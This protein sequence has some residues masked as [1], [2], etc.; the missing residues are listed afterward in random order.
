M[1]PVSDLLAGIV[2]K[3]GLR[4]VMISAISVMELEHGL[5]RAETPE[6]A[7][8][9]QAWIDEVYAAIPVQPFTKAMGQLTAKIDAEARRSGKVIPLA[10]LQIGVTAMHF[11]FELG[12]VNVRHFRLIPNLAVL[13]L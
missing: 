2:A 6:R 8:T 9:R 1:Q 4:Q 11:G 3:T 7:R 13:P 10:D 12:T 5:W